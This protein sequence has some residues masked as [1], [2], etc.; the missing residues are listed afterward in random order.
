MPNQN[1]D[2]LLSATHQNINNGTTIISDMWSGYKK[3]DEIHLPQPYIHQMNEYQ[4]FLFISFHLI[5]YLVIQDEFHFYF[6][7]LIHYFFFFFNFS[8]IIKK[9]KFLFRLS[10]F[11]KE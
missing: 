11:V 8:K 1:S 6:Q 9:I 7:N 10:K 4:S 5:V 3:L 2:T